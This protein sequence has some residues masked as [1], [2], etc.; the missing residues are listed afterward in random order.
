MHHSIIRKRAALLEW[1]Q[2]VGCIIRRSAVRRDVNLH[3][4]DLDI[5]SLLSLGLD[6]TGRGIYIPGVRRP[7]IFFVCLLS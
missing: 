3:Y 4:L 1:K 6:Y 2:R 7:S 5:T